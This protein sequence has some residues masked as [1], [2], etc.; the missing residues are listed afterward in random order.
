MLMAEL[1]MIS[2]AVIAAFLA[3]MPEPEPILAAYSVAFALHAT[4]GSPVWACQI[5]FLSF[6]RDRLAVR[7]LFAFGMQTV[8]A[9]AGIWL[10]LS[11]TPVGEIFLMNVFG[12]SRP[13]AEAA[14]L[15]LL[16]SLWIPPTSVVRSL[17]YAILMAER[18]TIYVTLGT[19]IR[20]AGLA[21]LLAVLT[22]WF[23]GA[24]VGILALAGCITVETVV[25]I[26]IAYP[27]YKRLAAAGK[28]V[29]GYREL[30]R[31]SW[32]IMMMQTA[33]SGVALTA[34]FFLGRLPRPELALAAFGVSESIMR[35][36]LSPL[37]NLIHTSQTLV[38][39]RADARVI[40][41]FSMHTAVIFG[42]LTL[43][44]FH[45][46]GLREL[47]LYDI[48]G[49]PAHMAEYVT[50]ALKMSVLLA[51]GMAAAGIARGLL[52]ASRNTG[53][54]A[55]SS[56]LRVF[57]VLL[58]GVVALLT[59]AENGAMVGMLALIVAFG[60]EAALLIW[61]LVRLDQKPIRLFTELSSQTGHPGRP[62]HANTKV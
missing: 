53:V 25:A 15:C 10:I 35:V 52:I 55:A 12:V 11:L 49:L 40:V 54:I 61:R 31:F 18:K 32:P 45:V 22:E 42:G 57:A 43:L 17:A 26:I 19:I 60:S 48:M 56:I 3:R 62:G 5:V 2:H 46:P 14:K 16:V 9:V 7:R 29:P 4:L 34:N 38:K 33:E 41:I 13:V 1:M 21:G 50:D 28:P 23:S 39:S 36:L 44:L 30:W 20:L 24:V 59:G 8:M 47:V 27:A 37:R 58:V 6:V 51:L